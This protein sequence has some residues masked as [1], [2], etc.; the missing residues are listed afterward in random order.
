MSLKPNQETEP[1]YYAALARSR[2]DWLIGIN[3]SRLFTLLAQ[4]QGYSGNPLSVGRVQSPTL[5][6]VVNRDRDIA[7]FIPQ[8][9]YALTVLLIT[10]HNEQFSA[11]YVVPKLY[12][13]ESG[14]C[15]NAAFIRNIQTEINQISVAQVSNI[16]TKRE[17]NAPPLL[18][19]LSDLQSECNKLFGM[20]GSASARYCSITL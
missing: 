1:F 14:L 13:D 15:L 4:Q 11:D 2:S 8:N 20:G 17:K 3:F 18:F 6:M 5:A 10:Q 12:L 19:A 16:E 9:H 7:N